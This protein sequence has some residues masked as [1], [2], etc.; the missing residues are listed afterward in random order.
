LLAPDSWS[1]NPGLRI[2][3]YEFLEPMFWTKEISVPC[4]FPQLLLG[5]GIGMSSFI[6]SLPKQYQ[7][8]ARRFVAELRMNL[9]SD[10]GASLMN[11]GDLQKP[12]FNS[13]EEDSPPPKK[14]RVADH[15]ESS[16]VA[17][18]EDGVEERGTD[19][20]QH[21]DV[22][23]AAA[24]KRQHNRIHGWNDLH[25]AADSNDIAKAQQLL[26]QNPELVHSQ[27]NFR[28][29]PL[30]YPFMKGH[31]GMAHLLL[32]NGAKILNVEDDF[33][34]TPL[35]YALNNGHSHMKNEILLWLKRNR[36]Y[37]PVTVEAGSVDDPEEELFHKKGSSLSQVGVNQAAVSSTSTSTFA[38]DENQL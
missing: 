8:T 31:Q 35:T 20:Q 14:R 10:K 28:R 15:L 32:D 27:D 23:G 6:S 2:E 34:V 12:V 18:G 29:T 30:F 24:K 33:K 11:D 25:V 17:F 26:K 37:V 21:P 7:P 5:T 19:I 4:F 3:F 38:R 9:L 22:P 1:A 13:F 16:A 36:P